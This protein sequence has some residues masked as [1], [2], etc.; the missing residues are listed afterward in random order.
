MEP[1]LRHHDRSQFA[2]TCYSD[3]DPEDELTAH[4]RSTETIWRQTRPLSDIALADLIRMDG[5]DILVDLTLH[6]RGCRLGMFAL[7]PAPIQITHLAYC[8]T[9]GLAQMD[10]CVTDA[11]MLAP[12]L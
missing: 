5:I 1:I 8:G 2:I 11:H 3:A 10:Y 12:R 7:K 6:M 4:L 9:S